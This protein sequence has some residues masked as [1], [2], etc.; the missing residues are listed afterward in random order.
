MHFPYDIELDKVECTIL[1]MLNIILRTNKVKD[2][3]QVST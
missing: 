1:S 3:S 2:Q